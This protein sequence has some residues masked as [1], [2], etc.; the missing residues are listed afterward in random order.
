[1][2]FIPWLD[3]NGLHAKLLINN[4]LPTVS[5]G[6]EKVNGQPVVQGAQAARQA[7]LKLPV[8]C[9]SAVDICDEVLQRQDT[10]AG[11]IELDHRNYYTVLSII[12]KLAGLVCSNRQ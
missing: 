2:G 3:A 9:E 4:V 12:V 6:S 8:Q 11:D 10:P 7:V 5:I 1:M